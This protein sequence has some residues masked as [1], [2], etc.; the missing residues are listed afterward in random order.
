LITLHFARVTKALARHQRLD[1][2]HLINEA[3]AIAGAAE[4]FGDLVGD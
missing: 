2:H 1:L 3:V 4:A